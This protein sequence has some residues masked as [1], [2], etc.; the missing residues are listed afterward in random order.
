M[1][2]YIRSA[3]APQHPTMKRPH[4]PNNE[5]SYPDG[6][7]RRIHHHRLQ[8]TQ[9]FHVDPL[10]TPQDELFFKSQMLRAISLHLSAIGFDSVKSTALEAFRA[11]VEEC[12]SA[13]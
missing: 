7:R 8:H 3:P 1:H 6:K 12:M 2:D 4:P 10:V 5:G 13:R 9:P 11:E